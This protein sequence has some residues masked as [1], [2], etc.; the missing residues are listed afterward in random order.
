MVVAEPAGATAVA[1]GADGVEDIAAP[2]VGLSVALRRDGRAEAGER[3][4]VEI[5]AGPLER[6][7]PLLAGP[8][9]ESGSGERLVVSTEFSRQAW[10]VPAMW[11]LKGTKGVWSR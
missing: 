8:D 6:E 10:A 11:V 4:P 3:P 9:L 5:G 1:A 2:G 7:D